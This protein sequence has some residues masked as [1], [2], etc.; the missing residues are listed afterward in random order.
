MTGRVLVVTNDFPPRR[1]GIESF[2][3]S[4]CEGIDPRSVVVYTAAMR[5][6]APLDSALPYPVVRDPGRILLPT[7]AVGRRVVATMSAYGCDRVAFGAAAPLG[8]LARRLRRAGAHRTVGLTHGHEIWWAK[9]PVTRSL[10]RRIGNQVDVVTYV[11]DFCRV[12]VAAALSKA[13]AVRMERLAPGVDT[14]RFTPGHDGSA[15]RASWGIDSNQPVVLSVSRFVR[16]KG[17]DRLIDAWPAV[18]RCHPEAVL[19]VLGDGP[20]G[21]ALHRRAVRRGVAKSVRVVAGVP[22]TQMPE[23]YAAADVFA[24]PCRTRRL[25]LEPEALGIVFLEAAASGLPV[26]VGRSGG[27]PETVVN[28]TTGYVVDPFDAGE[29]ADRLISLLRNPDAAR[30]MGARGRE[31]VASRFGAE[32]SRETFRQLLGLRDHAARSQRD[33]SEPG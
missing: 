22:W 26:V 5:G 20:R 17:H 33:V 10:L 15:R 4:L 12:P 29:V 14:E 9:L 27:A 16:R 7:P 32:S 24:V 23:V 18:V 1:G 28:E 2:V 19:V 6:S 31:L 3:Q 21:P 25:G 11:S 8:L 13:A 30:E